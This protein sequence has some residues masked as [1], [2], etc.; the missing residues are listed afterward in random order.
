MS[1]LLDGGYEISVVTVRHDQNQLPW[2]SALIR[3]NQEISQ[4]AGLD[5]E[6]DFLERNSALDLQAFVFLRVPPERLH[7]VV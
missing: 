5:G 7:T 4:P 3:V 1:A 2:I 6:D